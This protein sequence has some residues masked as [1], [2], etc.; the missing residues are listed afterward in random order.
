[1]GSHGDTAD[2]EGKGI[3]GDFHAAQNS[4][5]AVLPPQQ[6]RANTTA[7]SASWRMVAREGE[8]LEQAAVVAANSCARELLAV[9]KLDLYFS[10]WLRLVNQ[11]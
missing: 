6:T 10:W 4:K 8:V 2:G 3:Q 11:R 7:W 9:I 5:E 1:M